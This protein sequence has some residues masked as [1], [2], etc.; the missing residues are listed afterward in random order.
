M[1]NSSL[2]S[3]KVK[4][5]IDKYF[6]GSKFEW[7]VKGLSYQKLTKIIADKYCSGDDH[8]LQKAALS[9]VYLDARPVWFKYLGL[10][11]SREALYVAIWR[12]EVEDLD[13]DHPFYL[14]CLKLG[15]DNGNFEIDYS[16]DPIKLTT[17]D[18]FDIVD[19]GI[20]SKMLQTY[21]LEYKKD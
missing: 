5:D 21:K 8:Q 16:K 12:K 1:G 11:N 17:G 15:I 7:N 18:Y 9:I 2:P 4:S 13:Y 19:N 14:S 10:K 6:N 3:I 20:E